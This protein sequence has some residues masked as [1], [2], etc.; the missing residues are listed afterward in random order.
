MDPKT[1]D[2]P[3]KP[4]NDPKVTRQPKNQRGQQ[5]ER[6]NRQN[7][8]ESRAGRAAKKKAAKE[9][10]EEK[11]EN[12]KRDTCFHEGS[13]NDLVFVFVLRSPRR[14]QFASSPCPEQRN[15]TDPHLTV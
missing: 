8:F 7:K 2:H 1:R 12:K 11:T 4:G 10:E 14:R 9:E 13:Q 3:K 6:I 15:Q 5:K